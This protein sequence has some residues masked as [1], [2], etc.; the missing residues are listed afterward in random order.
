MKI[1]RRTD[2]NIYFKEDEEKQRYQQEKKNIVV[3]VFHKSRSCCYAIGRVTYFVYTSIDSHQAGNKTNFW[4]A[5]IGSAA[6]AAAAVAQ[7][8]TTEPTVKVTE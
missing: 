7:Q 8:T 1:L 4:S 3:V 5:S 2:I 6:A